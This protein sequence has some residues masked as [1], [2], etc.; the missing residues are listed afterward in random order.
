MRCLVYG[1]VVAHGRQLGLATP[2]HETIVAS[3]LPRELAARG[4]AGTG[5]PG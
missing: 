1:A 5:L 3:L 4:G 2:V